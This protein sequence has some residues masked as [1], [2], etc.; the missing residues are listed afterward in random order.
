MAT[1][2]N[3]AAEYEGANWNTTTHPKTAAVDLAPGDA[4][5][6]CGAAEADGLVISTPTG[7]GLTYTPLETVVSTNYAA[8]YTWGVASVSGQTFTLSL[9][10]NNFSLFWGFNAVRFSNSAGIGATAQAHVLSGAPSLNIDTTGDNSA[11]VVMVADFNAGDGS[12]RTWRTVNGITPSAG[13]GD[14]LTYFRDAAAYTVYVAYYSDAGAIGTCTVG[15]SAP[16]SQKYSMA[17]IEVLASD[18]PGPGGSPTAR[19]LMWYPNL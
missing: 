17:A 8:V 6:V 10:T 15:L 5:V 2:P 3:F 9:D 12:S 11:L 14:E 13:G 18:A 1:P 16:G 7:G 19:Q 4:L